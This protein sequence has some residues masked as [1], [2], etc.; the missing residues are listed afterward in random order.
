MKWK[1][2]KIRFMSRK[3]LKDLRR[4]KTI[5]EL[6]ADLH[7]KELREYYF[8]MDEQ[9]L[10]QGHSQQFHF[11][12]EGIPVIPTYIDVEEQRLI[13]YPISV[14]QYGLAIFHT[15]LKT[16]SDYDKQRFLTIVNWFCE[17]HIED[18][19]L[20]SYWL[21]DVPKPEYQV[22]KPWKSAFAQ[23]R[24]LSILLRGW[25][26]TGEQCYLDIATKALK[27]FSIPVSKGGVTSFIE[28]GPFYEEYTAEMPTLVLDGMVFSLCGLYDYVRAVPD[29]TF[30]QQL[31]EDGI[32][33]LA[34]SLP[35]YDL[36][37]W[38]RFN[39]CQAVFYPEIDPATIGYFRL[40]LTQLRMLYRLT[41]KEIFREYAEKWAGYDIPRNIARMYV[42]KY[43]ALKKI[44]RL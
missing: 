11:D 42:T 1:L 21:T 30:A 36:G 8:Y 33:C 3:L 4:D 27:P 2:K 18:D 23:S 26:L 38:I 17:H 5:Y 29:H 14:G 31:F 10:L 37:Y 6:A 20:G 39:R 24:G 25:Q 43:K 44:G 35:D 9:A 15:Y 16:Q 7:G 32:H 34:C 28:R 40:V 12:G 13:Y 22:F 41:H 19:R